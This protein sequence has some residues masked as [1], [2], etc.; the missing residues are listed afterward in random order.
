MLT[1]VHESLSRC[2]A[3]LIAKHRLKLQGQSRGVERI[4]IRRAVG[5]AVGLAMTVHES[6]C[7]PH[8]SMVDADPARCG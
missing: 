8:R 3:G 6:R 5:A 1:T 4:A 7:A 2:S